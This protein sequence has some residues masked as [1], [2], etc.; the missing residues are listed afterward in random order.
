MRDEFQRRLGLSARPRLGLLYYSS[1]LL[2]V[3]AFDGRKYVLKTADGA[4][5]IFDNV[6]RLTEHQYSDGE[7]NKLKYESGRLTR[8]T[9]SDGNFIDFAYDSASGK[10]RTASASTGQAVS[11]TTS[12]DGDLTESSGTDVLTY[13][14][15]DRHNLTRIGYP[16]GTWNGLTYN[17]DKDWVTS[18]RNR[19]GCLEKYEYNMDPKDPKNIFGR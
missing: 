16:D 15:D 18:F 7:W 19:K 12:P 9:G 14:Y 8:V 10:V 3:A 2:E 5:Y 17:N 6:G 13:E 1:N 4:R 11:Y